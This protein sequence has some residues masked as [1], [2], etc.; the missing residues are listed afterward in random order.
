MEDYRSLP[1]STHLP[2]ALYR[3]DQLRAFDRVAIEE[4]AI[5]GEVLMERAGKAA[6]ELLVSRWPEARHLTVVAGT[7]NNGGDGFVLARLAR[8][9]GLDVRVLQLGD[10]ER[11]GGD[12][13]RIARRYHEA[14]GIWD[15]YAGL[16]QRTDVIVDALL[17]TGLQRAVKGAWADAIQAINRHH[18]PVLAIDVPSGLDADSGNILGHSVKAV[19]TITFIGLK[20][21]MFT[22]DGPDCCGEIHFE[23]LDIPARVYASQLLAA[24]RIDWARQASSLPPRRRTAHKGHYGHVL[25]V[26]GDHGFGGAA[27]MAAEAAL[28]TG[29]GLVS[30]A[31]RAAHVSAAL[32]ARPEIMVHGIES[33]DELAPL[34][35]RASVVVVGP[36]LGHG[37]WGRSLWERICNCARPKVIDADA[38]TLLAESPRQGK[39]W[40]LTPHPG[41]AARLLGVCAA[42]VQEDRFG[43]VARLHKRYGGV[44]VLKGAGSLVLGD[45]DLPVAV[46]SAGNPGMASGG[47]GDVLSGVIAGLLAQGQ[48]LQ[49]AA[50]MGVCLHAASADRVAAARGERGLLAMDLMPEIPRLLNQT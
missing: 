23:S 44:A 14:G 8:Q 32:A 12:A 22:A 30:L 45:A 4:F 28:R 9:A 21:G 1:K 15:D 17:G 13:A 16:P 36:G 11:I 50:E 29:A 38:L 35:N 26:G 46:C 18:A 10:R 48:A 39:D 3:A 40:V 43:S 42:D 19:A 20:Q 24:R 41:E 31:T 6:F 37:V 47:M 7:G 5:P 33:A 34:L 27:R 49:A 25:V 2:Y